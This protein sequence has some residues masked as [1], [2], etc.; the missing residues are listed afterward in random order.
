MKKKF[1]QKRR[2]QK[3]SYCKHIVIA[4]AYISSFVVLSFGRNLF[5]ETSS[6]ETKV[7]KDIE[8]MQEQEETII[9]NDQTIEL[10]AKI[11]NKYGANS[12]KTQSLML[13]SAKE[14]LD[15]TQW[16]LGYS[17][18]SEEY[19]ELITEIEEKLQVEPTKKPQK[20]KLPYTQEEISMLEKIVE[21]EATGEDLKGKILIANVIFNRT[22]DKRFPNTI[23]GVIFHKVKGKY[24]FSPISDKRYYSV[25][26]TEE[27]KQAVQRA[28]A[29]EDYSKGALYFMAREQA[30]VNNVKWFDQNLQ[31]LFS[32][33]CHEFFK[34]K[35]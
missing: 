25:K 30:N 7:S 34:H 20:T 21:A 29:G 4:M 28:I 19:N 8:N 10:L 3:N 22:K 6:G 5:F 23:E 26:V 14:E 16:F 13:N 17:M 2:V 18:N 33:G 15:Q 11:P 35:V 1:L 12:T 24:Q 32:H 31:P 9:E 27:S